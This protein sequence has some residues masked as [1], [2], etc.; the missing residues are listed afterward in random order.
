MR[1]RGRNL[2]SLWSLESILISIL[3]RL[4]RAWSLCTC[5]FLRLREGRSLSESLSEAEI[6][7]VVRS[8]T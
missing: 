4:F 2:G 1:K 6:L 3:D 5:T 7:A 8:D